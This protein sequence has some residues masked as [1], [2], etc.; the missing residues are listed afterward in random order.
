MFNKKR[1]IKKLKLFQRLAREVCGMFS[2]RDDYRA[3]WKSFWNG[4]KVNLE[5]V[6]KV[7]KNI[8]EQGIVR[9]NPITKKEKKK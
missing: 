2:N 4:K 1:V 5:V 9:V 8:E 7:I 6:D 3:F